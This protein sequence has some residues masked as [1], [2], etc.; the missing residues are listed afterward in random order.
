[1]RLRT[2]IR[3]LRVIH[4]LPRRKPNKPIDINQTS[5]VAEG[6]GTTIAFAEK[7][8]LSTARPSSAALGTCGSAHRSHKSVPGAQEMPLTVAVIP[9]ILPAVFPSTFVPALFVPAKTGDVKFSVGTA[10]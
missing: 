8:T 10:V 4:V 2:A 9:L 6:S 7:L 1:M 3:F 5:A